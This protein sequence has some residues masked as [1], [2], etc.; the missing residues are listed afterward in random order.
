[1]LYTF[2]SNYKLYIS[3]VNKGISQYE[4]S[5]EKATPVDNETLQRVFFGKKIGKVGE[6]L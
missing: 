6:H 4:F 1:M 3:F 2:Y 5:I